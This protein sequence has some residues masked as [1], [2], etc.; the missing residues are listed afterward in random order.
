[1]PQIGQFTRLRGLFTGDI[2]TL[3]IDRHLVLVPVANPT[4]GSSPSYTIHLKDADGPEVGAA[5][6]RTGDRVGEYLSLLL[7]DPTLAAP[8]RA[9]LFQK[10]DDKKVWKLIWKREETRRAKPED[11]S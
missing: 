5:W 11:A 10:D 4:T 1:M 7:D 6:K 2:R 9:N 8:L 3:L